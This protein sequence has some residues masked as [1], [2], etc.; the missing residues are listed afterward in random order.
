MSSFSVELI[1]ETGSLFSDFISLGLTPS[2]LATALF[3]PAELVFSSEI[4]VFSLSFFNGASS[5]NS[6]LPL[7]LSSPDS[8]LFSCEFFSL[9]NYNM[10]H[11]FS[12]TG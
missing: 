11:I 5:S 2:K 12:V 1:D 6:S 3:F 8:G 9:A 10:V 4:I 7:R